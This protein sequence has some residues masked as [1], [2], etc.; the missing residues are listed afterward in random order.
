MN[1]LA[2]GTQQPVKVASQVEEKVRKE[3]GE[4]GPVPYR[5]ESGAANATTAGTVMGDVVRGL[6]GGN[7]DLLFTLVFDLP[8]PQRAQLRADVSRQGIGCHVG[9]LLYSAYL[10][11]PIAG[12]LEL[13]APRMF[14]AAKFVGQADAAR[15]FNANGELLN[16]LAKLSRTEAQIGGLTLKAERVVK[17]APSSGDT[18]VLVGTLPRS[19]SIGMDA[20]LDAGEF[21]QL[22]A[23]MEALV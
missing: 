11:R 13:E 10:A 1:N 21:L 18:L 4:T 7:P 22:A 5:I 8:G 14:G 2:Y 6:F 3:T 9:K 16:R 19:T 17:L 12:E 20:A 15:R 23:M